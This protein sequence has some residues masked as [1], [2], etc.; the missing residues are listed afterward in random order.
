[1]F[2]VFARA[3]KSIGVLSS[4]LALTVLTA[5]DLPTTGGGQKVD[6]NKPVVVALLVP[7]GSGSAQDA[8]LASSLENAARLA[9][10]ELSGVKIDLRV[11]NTAGKP[12]QAASVATK[13][14]NDG[15]KIILGPVFAQA[16]NAVGHTVAAQNVNVLSFSNNTDIAGGNVFVLGN[17]F[18]NTANRLVQYAAKSG[19]GHIFVLSGQ[20]Q[21]ENVGNVA[22]QNAIANSRATLAGAS[23]FELS[24][25][26]IVGAM[27]GIS[28][29]IK[30][31]GAQSVFFTSGTSGALPFL[32]GLLPENGVTSAKTQFAGLQRWDIPSNALSLPGLQGGWFTLPDPALSGGFSQR[33]QARY[34]TRPHLIAGV[35]YDGIAAIGALLKTG[36]SNALTVKSLTQS[37]GFVGVNGIF[38]LRADGTNQRALA[39][40]QIQNN[41][42]V[43][44][45]P[46]PKSFGGAEF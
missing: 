32:A 2:S 19:K 29:K 21:A 42:T 20:N 44:I 11:Y 23:S 1:M 16:A 10:S 45:D 9:I 22:I 41:K 6:P 18:Q 14:V 8:V 5:C 24:Q 27:P 28:S 40:A 33:Y 25:N 17:T 15:A 31:S 26:G 12:N 13:A 7:S 35:A 43:I 46:A 30:S 4:I 36:R 37:K 39:V 34:G 38:R 3:R